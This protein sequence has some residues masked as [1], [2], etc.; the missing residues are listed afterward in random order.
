[1]CKNI[2]LPAESAVFTDVRPGP[3][4]KG[5]GAD[6]AARWCYT[7]ADNVGT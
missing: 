3:G 2:E 1:M 5:G 4:Q 6:T 7:E